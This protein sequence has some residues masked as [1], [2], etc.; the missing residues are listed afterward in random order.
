[1][2]KKLIN[3]CITTTIVF[4]IST[5]AYAKTS[6][7]VTRLCGND[8]YETSIKIA[9][10][11]QSGTLQNVI[12]AS[13]SNFPDALAGSILSKKYNAPILL[14]NSDLNSNSEQL[15]YIKNNVDKNGNVYI[16]GGTG[17][18]SDK[19]VNH[20]KDLGYNNITRLGGDNRFS[21][22]KEIVDSMN[23]K[24][25]TP[26]VIANGY[27]FADALSISSVA[28]DNGYP[29]FMT[30]ADSL[31]DETKDLI[32]SINPSTVYIIGGQAS[33]EDKVLTQ[34]KSLVPSLSD[35]NIKRIDGQ[36]RYD[37]SLNICK[38]FNVNT[39]TAVLASGVNF[40]DALSGSTLASKLNAPIILTD[41][42]NITNQ[43]S[44]MDP[45]GYKNVTIL[46]GFASVD[47][48]VEYQIV[49]PSK[50][51]QAEKDYLNNLK[52][53]C[54]SYKQETDTFLNNLDTVQNK[55]SN[56]KSTSTYNTVKD[57]DNSISQSISAVNE[58]NS[59][60]SDYKNNL[61]SLKDK[62]ANLQ[63]PDKLSNLNSQYLN[64]I[65]TQIDDIGKS[66]E[67]MNSYVY[68]FNSFKQAV[69]DLDFDK[70]KSIGNY[71]IQSPDIQ[72]GSAGISSLYDTVNAAINSLQQ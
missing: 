59:Y 34:L 46:G 45:K 49:D 31:P 50:I 56:L 4:G 9:E 53:Y 37:T 3:F 43:K 6:Y 35:D 2:L 29:I 17:S 38:Y 54:E 72:T 11:F 5:A 36:T 60:L 51:P 24:S 19:F 67:Y 25:G 42:K 15:N 57:I 23:V 65:N 41:G 7:N 64:N 66:I 33:V 69:D 22:N 16:L 55:I 10:N 21:T 44:F 48:A 58:V 1:M 62:V 20:I 63:V 47:L 13:G 18:V 61:N 26:I 52:N 30:K 28:A 70:A 71:I 68:K 39:D 12:L 27:G 32:L 14:I 8:R 40:P